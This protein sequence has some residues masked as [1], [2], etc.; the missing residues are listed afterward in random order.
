M[1][2]QNSILGRLLKKNLKTGMIT[3]FPFFKELTKQSHKLTKQQQKDA[4]R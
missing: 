3:A 2:Y 1:C 4:N